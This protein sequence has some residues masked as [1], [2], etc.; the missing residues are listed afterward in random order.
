MSHQCQ[1]KRLGPKRKKTLFAQQHRRRGSIFVGNQC[2]HIKLFLKFLRHNLCYKRCPKIWLL[3]G[4]FNK[5]YYLR[6]NWILGNVWKNWATVY[7][8]IWSHCN[9]NASQLVSLPPHIPLIEHG[10]GILLFRYCMI[11]VYGPTLNYDKTLMPYFRHKLSL[12]LQICTIKMKM[13][14]SLEAGAKICPLEN[15]L[16]TSNHASKC[17]RNF[18]HLYY[19][20]I[21]FIVLVSPP[22]L[23]LLSRSRQR[24]TY[25]IFNSFS[26]IRLKSSLLL[27]PLASA[28]S[29]SQSVVYNKLNEIVGA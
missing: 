27:L 10:G 6:K 22:L 9:G 13:T 3:F 11:Y 4:Y 12:R 26:S 23:L 20:K 21:S 25:L 8:Y 14:Q 29:P 24:E 5:H 15:S 2:D 28:S 7:T 17:C 19:G 1:T 18:S 16:S